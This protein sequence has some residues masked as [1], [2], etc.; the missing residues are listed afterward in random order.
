MKKL[1]LIIISLF[2]IN[3]CQGLS[4]NFSFSNLFSFGA[5]KEDS[6][7]TQNESAESEYSDEYSKTDSKK[8]YAQNQSQESVISQSAASSHS[9]IHAPQH[10]SAKPRLA[11]LDSSNNPNRDAEGVCN[12]TKFELT[13]EECRIFDQLKTFCIAHIKVS[14]N[15]VVPCRAK[16]KH[17]SVVVGDHTEVHLTF[18]EFDDDR[19]DLQLIRANGVHFPYIAKFTYTEMYFRA[20]GK[21]VE[22]AISNGYVMHGSRNVTELP[23]Y[24]KGKWVQ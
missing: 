10:S 4:P 1:S 18:T 7:E 15:N 8:N 19:I 21:T 20:K 16:P 9:V 23:R 13:E 2:L 6:I 11:S 5:N 22:E 24:M 14:N 17:E 3:G 12:L